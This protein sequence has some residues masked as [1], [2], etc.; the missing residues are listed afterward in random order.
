[1]AN[2]DNCDPCGEYRLETLANSKTNVKVN[3]NA[4][5]NETSPW[6]MAEHEEKENKNWNLK[7]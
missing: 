6:L 2:E 1:M 5:T 7:I 4:H 3:V